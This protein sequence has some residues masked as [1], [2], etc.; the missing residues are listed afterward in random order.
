MAQLHLLAVVAVEAVAFDE[1]GV[2]ALAPEDVLEGARHRGGAGAGRAGDRDDGMLVGHGWPLDA[3]SCQARNRP[4]SANSGARIRGAIVLAVVAL[5]ALDLVARAEDE[6]DALVQRRRAAPRARGW[7]PVLAR[8]PACSMMQ[9]DRVG[10][11]QQAQAPRLAPGPCVSRGYRNTPPRI[12]M[13]C[14]SATSEAIQRMLKS[15]PRGPVW[16][17]RHSST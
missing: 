14:A 12:R 17:A 15:L 2:D 7:R 9:R 11:V 3:E 10:L 8:P 5:D 6:A 13:R 1:G 4:R 16:P